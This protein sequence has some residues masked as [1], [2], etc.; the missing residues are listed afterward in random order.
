LPRP[1]GSRLLYRPSDAHIGGITHSIVASDTGAIIKQFEEESD[2]TIRRALLLSLGE[3]SEKDLSHDT[4][5]ALLPRLQAI[6]RT[7]ADAGLHAAAEWL[8]RRWKEE[9]SLKQVNE[10]WANKEQREKRLDNIGE[11]LAKDREKTL[12]Q[13]YVND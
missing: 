11:A 13:W 1:S 3:Y 4:R 7:D 9:A 10:E 12:P 2:I 8:L 6:Y 5:K